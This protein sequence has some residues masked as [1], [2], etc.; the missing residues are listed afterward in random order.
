MREAIAMEESGMNNQPNV[1]IVMLV[2]ALAAVAAT[3]WGT[4]STWVS[5]PEAVEEDSVTAQERE[6]VPAQGDET[7]ASETSDAS[8]AAPASD[9]IPSN[10]H[11]PAASERPAPTILRERA[12]QPPTTIE[13][14]TVQNQIRARVGG[15][16]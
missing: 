15:S 11:I 7:P 1:R 2:T 8:D 16:T 14:R 3:A 12:P 9:A 6:A 10:A 4:N 5:A 13:D